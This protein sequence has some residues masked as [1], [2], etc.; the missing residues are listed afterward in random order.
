MSEQDYKKQIEAILF[1]CG[2][3]VSVQELS[4]LLELKSTP[5]IKKFLQELQEEYA[6]RE[7]PIMITE[8]TN[9]FK[10]VTAERYLPLVQKLIPNAELTKSVMETLAVIA[11]KQPVLQAEVIKMRTSKAYEQIGE[12]L[13]AGFISK[14]KHGRSYILKLTTKFNDYFD[15]PK[16]QESKI[17]DQLELVDPQ[18]KVEEYSEQETVKE[19]TKLEQSEPAQLVEQPQLEQKD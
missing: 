10:M 13:N 14:E 18:T 15:L 16:G 6:Q 1:A 7:S 11:W 17:F 8:D 5:S 4:S 12:L 9:E 3:K 2:R 19:T